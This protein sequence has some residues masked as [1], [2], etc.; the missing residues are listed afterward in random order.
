MLSFSYNKLCPGYFWEDLVQTCLFSIWTFNV[1]QRRS[2]L[3]TMLAGLTRIHG[4]HERS[5]PL[6]FLLKSKR[7]HNHRQEN[8]QLIAIQKGI[9][10]NFTISITGFLDLPI[11]WYSQKNTFRPQVKSWWI[12]TQLDALRAS[13]NHWTTISSQLEKLLISGFLS[14]LQ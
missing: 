5:A 13:L 6:P 12:P 8:S 11:V 7:H 4:Q 1:F 14:G 3:L 2:V 10:N 9:I